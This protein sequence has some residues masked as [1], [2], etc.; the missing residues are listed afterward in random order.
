MN[1]TAMDDMTITFDVS[2]E[3]AEQKGAEDILGG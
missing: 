2:Y 1:V 3:M